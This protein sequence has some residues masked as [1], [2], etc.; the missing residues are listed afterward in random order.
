MACLDVLSI[1]ALAGD[2]QFADGDDFHGRM[3]AAFHFSKIRRDQEQQVCIL[4]IGCCPF[5]QL[6][7]IRVARH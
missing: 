4:A 1:Q 3:V 7:G 5:R 6:P 2:M